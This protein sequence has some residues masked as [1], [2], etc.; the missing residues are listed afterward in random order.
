MKCKLEYIW[1][2]GERPEPNIRSK[3]KIW[4]FEALKNPA[5]Q[6]KREMSINGRLIPCPEELPEWSFDGSSTQQAKGDKSDCILK[7]V[8]VVY[9]PA[10]LDAFLVM[11]EVMNSDGTPHETNTR[12]GLS[13]DK[14][15]WLDS[16]KLYNDTGWKA[17]ISLEDG[18]D[19]TVN[20]VKENLNKFDNENLSFNLRA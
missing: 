13:E 2:S 3:T 17:K 19:E 10:R 20:W 8:R 7:P 11:C 15:Y 18:I 14:Q 4:D 9:D 12:H 16:T 6:I 5:L 1:L